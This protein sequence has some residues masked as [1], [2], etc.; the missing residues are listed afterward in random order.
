MLFALQR[1]GFMEIVHPKENGAAL[2]TPF[3]SPKV[4]AKGL[5][6]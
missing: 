4:K 5:K 3:I 2:A 6:F 1:Y